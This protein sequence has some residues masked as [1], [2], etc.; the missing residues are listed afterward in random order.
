MIVKIEIKYTSPILRRKQ[1]IIFLLN[2]K[3]FYFEKSKLN[4]MNLLGL[5]RLMAIK[6]LVFTS[7]QVFAD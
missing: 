3:D 4:K 6:Q 7:Q 1:V 2:F 5:T